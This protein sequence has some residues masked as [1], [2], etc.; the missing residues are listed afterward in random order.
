MAPPDFLHAALTE[1]NHVGLSSRKVASSS[2]TPP[3]STGNPGSVYTI[4][5]TAVALFSLAP[6]QFFEETSFTHFCLSQNVR[7]LGGSNQGWMK[8]DDRIP[9]PVTF[10]AR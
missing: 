2:M 9:I 7:L 10:V 1:G 3:S 4:C 6:S 5:E 8:S